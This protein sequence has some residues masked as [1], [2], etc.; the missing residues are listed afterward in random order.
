MSARYGSKTRSGEAVSDL[1]RRV[2]GGGAGG[3]TQLYEQVFTA[4][5]TWT[6]PATTTHVDVLLVGG[7]GGGGGAVYAAFPYPTPAPRYM[8]AGGGGGGGVRVVSGVPVS[9]PVPVLVGA[10]GAGGPGSGTPQYGSNGGDSSFGPEAVGGGGG[11]A[12]LDSTLLTYNPAYGTSQYFNA[13][14]GVGASAPPNG[15]GGGGGLAWD[16]G[17]LGIPTPNHGTMFTAGGA[18]GSN[19]FPGA[20]APN[21]INPQW[22]GGTGGGSGSTVPGTQPIGGQ[23]F[24]SGGGYL[25]YGAGGAGG[26]SNPQYVSTTSWGPSTHNI[27]GVAVGFS[28]ANGLDNTGQGGGGSHLDGTGTGYAGGAGGSGVVIVRWFE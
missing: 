2:I 9:G 16:Y 3:L 11:G 17:Y 8:S 23:V 27:P 21:I 10:G 25:G 15:G 26:Y 1:G 7:G 18:G 4:P 6:C 22:V 14:V 12:G 13:T 19:G 28:G 5:G 24:S 20:T